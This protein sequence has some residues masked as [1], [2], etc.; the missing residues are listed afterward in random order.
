M[1]T[2]FSKNQAK[3]FFSLFSLSLQAMTTAEAELE[4]ASQKR[5]RDDEADAAAP[6]DAAPAAKAARCEEEYFFLTRFSI[7]MPSFF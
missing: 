1:L 2:K 7:S 4:L 5:P 6:V 3:H